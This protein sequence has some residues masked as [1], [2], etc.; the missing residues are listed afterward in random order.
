MSS[1]SLPLLDMVKV[2]ATNKETGKQHETEMTYGQYLEMEKNK[3]FRYKAWK[4]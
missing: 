4:I 1:K 3:T 2:I